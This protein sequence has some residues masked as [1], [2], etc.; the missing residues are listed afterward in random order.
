MFDA[1]RY[2]EKKADSNTSLL[3]RLSVKSKEY[4]L[5]TLHRAENVDHEEPLTNILR[6][7]KN[8]NRNFVWPM[9]PRTKQRLLKLSESMPSNINVIDPVGYLDMVLLEKHASL[10]ATDSGGVQKEAYFHRVPCVTMREETEWVELVSAGVN[11]LTGAHT[12]Q[13]V[14]ALNGHAFNLNG[15]SGNLYGDGYAAKKIV[16]HILEVR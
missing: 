15:F 16:E 3:K 9:H 6:A 4:V 11:V 13:I 1:A 12:D 10:I 5:V 8:S 7:F 2:Y 14:Q